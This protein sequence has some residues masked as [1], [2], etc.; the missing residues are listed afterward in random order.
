M[1][2]ETLKWIRMIH[3]YGMLT[4]VGSLVG[5]SFIL[6]QHTKA[7]KAAYD[8]F[9]QLEKGTAMAMDI[10]A[11]VVIACGLAMLLSNTSIYLKGQGWMH[12]KLL[13]VA[14]LIGLHGLQ[15][16][17]TGKFKRGEVGAEPGWLIPAVEV[18]ALGIIVLAS[19]RPF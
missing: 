2:F 15:R 12:A 17:R 16:V 8:D 13:L 18:V 9:I 10:G 14:A 6:K 5:L 4:W 11:T 3:I 19:A 7:A 1:S